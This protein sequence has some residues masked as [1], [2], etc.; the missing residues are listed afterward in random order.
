MSGGA[1]RYFNV[2]GAF[3][4]EPT[5]MPRGYVGRKLEAKLW[6]EVHESYE[7][8]KRWARAR[9]SP[10]PNV[11]RN[12]RSYMRRICGAKVTR[13]TPGDLPVCSEIGNQWD[14]VSLQIQVR[15]REAERSTMDRQKSAE[16]MSCWRTA[17]KEEHEEMNRNGAIDV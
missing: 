6:S 12:L 2:V 17:T 13:L 9:S 14:S 5:A 11:I 4:H 7:A 10:K 3:L 16:S 1:I 8:A 15:T